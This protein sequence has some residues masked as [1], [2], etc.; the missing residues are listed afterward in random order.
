MWFA[1][2][3]TPR[4][5]RYVEMSECLPD[6]EKGEQLVHESFV[7]ELA[8]TYEHRQNINVLLGLSLHVSTLDFYQS[9]A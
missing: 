8:R 3:C 4:E 1:K 5:K 2:A 9:L 7:R 6:R